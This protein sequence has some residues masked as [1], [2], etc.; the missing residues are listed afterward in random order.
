MCT[1][2]EM[3]ESRFSRKLGTSVHGYMSL[4]PLCG[5]VQGLRQGAAGGR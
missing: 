2:L 1:R 4:C 3:K 5:G